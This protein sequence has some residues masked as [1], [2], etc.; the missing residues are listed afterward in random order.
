MSKTVHGS[1]FP[2]P[3]KVKKEEPIKE[4]KSEKAQLFNETR[5]RKAS[6]VEDD[7]AKLVVVESYDQ[8]MTQSGKTSSRVVN[9]CI[10]TN[11]QSNELQRHD[12]Q[13]RRS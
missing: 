10:L 1:D 4:E 6:T 2:K 5:K 3:S 13:S 7:A 12:S 11:I 8:G 9:D